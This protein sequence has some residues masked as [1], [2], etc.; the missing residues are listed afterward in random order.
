[1]KYIL[2]LCLICIAT[3]AI[4]QPNSSSGP[5]DNPYPEYIETETQA[6]PKKEIREADVFWK[7][8]IYRRI[9]VNEKYNHK[10][11]YNAD[12]YGTAWS[13][14]SA[15]AKPFF[16]FIKSKILEGV[17]TPYEDVNFKEFRVSDSALYAFLFNFPT[18]EEIPNPITNELEEKEVLVAYD[19][20]DIEAVR[21]K[22]DWYFDEQ[23]SVMRVDIL[24]IGFDFKARPD[25]DF[26]AQRGRFWMYY[27][28]IRN[29][30]AKEQ[31]YNEK[32][33]AIRYNWDA[34]FQ[35]RMFSSYI[36]KESNIFERSIIS[37]IDPASEGG[38]RTGV[39]AMIEGQNIQ[40]R[41]KELEMSLWSY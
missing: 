5:L 28:D 18:I 15:D 19:N 12:Q 21:I 7:K 35:N 20:N 17:I 22:E 10:F 36:Y 40:N 23:H 14:A 13:G 25:K 24:A 32:N 1:M 30:L 4:A 8:R 39:K 31:V 37:E 34:V 41:I 11:I 9:M 6:I 29:V 33:D 26:P 2:S 16:A 27:P 3:L 38:Y